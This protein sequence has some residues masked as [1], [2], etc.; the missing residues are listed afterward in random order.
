MPVDIDFSGPVFFRHFRGNQ[1]RARE[2]EVFG[3][4]SCEF[5]ARFERNPGVEREIE[6]KAFLPGSF[7]QGFQSHS[8]Q[9][10]PGEDGDFEARVNPDAVTWV[11]IEDQHV[12]TVH[13]DDGRER[14]VKFDGG[15]VRRPDQGRKIVKQAVIR[16]AEPRRPDPLLAMVRAL[17][18]I[19][20]LS[21]DPVRISLEGE[22]SVLEVGQNDGSDLLIVAD[23]LTFRE[24]G[25]REKYFRKIRELDEAALD[26]NV[27]VSLF[28][29]AS[30][31]ISSSASMSVLVTRSKHCFESRPMT[32]TFLTCSVGLNI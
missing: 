18:F 16:T 31:A 27:F 24:T 5:P 22:R 7:C 21:Q 30:Q 1:V 29:I 10:G 6:M 19:E 17:L 11:E 20:A 28:R 25:F 9:A 15:E 12:R 8:G 4:L 23:E 2:F 32:S 26:R 3:Q 14:R 13:V